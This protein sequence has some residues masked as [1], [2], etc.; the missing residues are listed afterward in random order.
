MAID[1]LQGDLVEAKLDTRIKRKI[2][3]EIEKPGFMFVFMLLVK[4]KN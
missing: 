2:T 1:R 3:Y 4:Q